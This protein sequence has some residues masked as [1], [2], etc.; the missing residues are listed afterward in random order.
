MV[1]EGVEAG[2]SSRQIKRKIL[3][4]RDFRHLKDYAA[5]HI[6]GDGEFSSKAKAAV[7]LRE[8]LQDARLCPECGARIHPFGSDIDHD[9]RKEEG[10]SAGSENA[11]S[12]HPFCNTG[13]KERRT[14]EAKK[15][16]Q[17]P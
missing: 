4:N 15:K 12:M 3:A 13:V 11:Q 1:L 8:I 14:A 5:R 7:R 17:T 6:S 9:E 2:K 10:G 16:R